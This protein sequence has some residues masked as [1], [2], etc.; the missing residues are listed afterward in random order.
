MKTILSTLLLLAIVAARAEE[1]NPSAIKISKN[2]VSATVSIYD[3][4]KPL[5]VRYNYQPGDDLEAYP[6]LRPLLFA[7]NGLALQVPRDKWADY[8]EK[9]W[10][11]DEYDELEADL[12][13]RGTNPGHYEF[14]ELFLCKLNE[15]VYLVCRS[16]FQ[17]ES[18]SDGSKFLGY[19]D[20]YLK[21]VDGVWVNPRKSARK[22]LAAKLIPCCA[23]ARKMLRAGELMSKPISELNQATEPAGV[24]SR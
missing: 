12:K 15:D 4:G 8:C 23:E 20:A 24:P 3:L 13:K 5:T 18:K 11:P 1:A 22:E 17:L 9:G 16:T 10:T 6:W 19:Q 21:R 2:G 7:W 14:S